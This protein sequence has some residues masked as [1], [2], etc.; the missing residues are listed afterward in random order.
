LA[1]EGL[2]S[3]NVRAVGITNQR[4]TTVVWDKETGKPLHNTL[5]W[6]DTRTRVLVNEYVHKFSADDGPGASKF[7]DATGLPISTYFSAMKIRWLIDN[8][9]AVKDAVERNTAA[10]GTVDSWIMWVRNAIHCR[11]NQ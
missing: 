1:A 2:S 11:W 6:L 3:S 8:V 5:V 9:P 7:R 4:E 10:F